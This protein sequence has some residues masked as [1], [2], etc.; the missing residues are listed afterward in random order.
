[1]FKSLALVAAV[2]AFL[3][4]AA[5]VDA[6]T[7]LR[8]PVIADAT[9]SADQPNVN[10]GASQNLDFGKDY[11]SSPSYRVWMT[12]GHVMFDVSPLVGATRPLRARLMWYQD[13]ARTQ[14]AGCLAVSVHRA[15]LPWIESAVTWGTQPPFDP[16]S[17]TSVPV[18][19]WDCSGWKAFDITPLVFDWIDGR[20]PN[21]GLVIRDPS[22]SSAGAA[23]PG[24][25]VSREGTNPA[26][27]PYVEIAYAVPYGVG[28]G[29]S[30]GV[31]SLDLSNGTPQTN[32]SHAL[33]A[34][35]LAAGLAFAWQIGISDQTWNGLR[36]PADLTLIG[37]AGCTL[38]ASGE[39][40]LGGVASPAGSATLT[41]P[42]RDDPTLRGLMLF[43][44]V[45][46]VDA[47]PALRLSN[48]CRV[49]IH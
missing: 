47:T 35:Q 29:P 17:V 41:F 36:L 33:T 6:Q 3:G 32:G 27:H 23:R 10:F 46:A 43:H 24:H 37:F 22:E 26:F 19:G 40:V 49:R 18:G 25:G 13:R 5:T 4:L 44:Q 11:V 12:R 30:G 38:L 8:L 34:T 1:M 45:V 20:H 15:T 2:A 9:T 16:A 28:C 39:I 7:H 31:P 48:G 42:V 14:P 21:F